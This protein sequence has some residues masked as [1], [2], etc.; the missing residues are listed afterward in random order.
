MAT[1]DYFALARQV[2]ADIRKNLRLCRALRSFS[3]VVR[4]VGFEP[5]TISLKGSCS[6]A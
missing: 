5:T 6:T 2:I 4:P 3:E 1:K